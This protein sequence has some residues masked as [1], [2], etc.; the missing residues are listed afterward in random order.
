MSVKYT[1]Q[2][3]KLVAGYRRNH[4]PGING[5]S[6]RL[7]RRYREALLL[8]T[9]IICCCYLQAAIKPN[10]LFSEHAV[11][12]Q[13]ISVPVWGT[14]DTGEQITIE[15]NGQRKQATTVNNKWMIQLD[16][17]PAGGPYKLVISGKND[18][19]EIKDIMII[20]MNHPRIT[21]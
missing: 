12:Q 20:R 18:K 2:Q 15:F 19:I 11:F 7:S 6:R 16:A 13:G 8:L 14:A 3:L 10:S 5:I 17:M 1:N 4:W 21:I 9:A